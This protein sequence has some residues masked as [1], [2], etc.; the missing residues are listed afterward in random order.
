MAATDRCGICNSRDV[1]R[2][3]FSPTNV[4]ACAECGARL[5][6]HPT[7]ADGEWEDP[8]GYHRA[9]AIP[10]PQSRD[11][12]E[13]LYPGLKPG[14]DCKTYGHHWNYYYGGSYCRHC[15]LDTPQPMGR[16]Q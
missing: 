6:G 16:D 8:S 5:C 12:A 4:V 2:D 3:P 14:R 9:A 15:G 10:Q 13:K 1:Q 7:A 11:E